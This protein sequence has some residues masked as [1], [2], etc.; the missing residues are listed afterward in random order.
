MAKRLGFVTG[1]D[2]FTP[3]LDCVSS[4]FNFIPLA[5]IVLCMIKSLVVE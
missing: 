1:K 4:A 3:S 5:I 2:A